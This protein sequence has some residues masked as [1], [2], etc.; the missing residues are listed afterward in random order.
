[1]DILVEKERAVV[2]VQVKVVAL[3]AV[4]LMT[5]TAGAYAQA[6]QG[7]QGQPAP[8]GGGAGRGPAGPGFT[9]TTT[10]FSD[11]AEIPT[12]YTQAD[13]NP[14]SPTLEWSNVPA[15]TAS[16]VL[17]LHDPDTA[18][19][20]KTEDILHWMM[21]NIPGTSREL[22]EGVPAGATLADGTIQVKNLRGNAGFMGP[23]APAPGPHHHYTFELYALD[24]KLELGPDATRPDVLKAIDGHILAKAVLVGR[25]HR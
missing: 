25:F 11:G 7:S 1:L 8:G 19:Q 22:P 4:L 17:I 5:L 9:L 21:F 6:P 13:P 14:V 15:N 3:G 10:A 2:K 16:F 12:R 23:G 24:T 20:K 18:P